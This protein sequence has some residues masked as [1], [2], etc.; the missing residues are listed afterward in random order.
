MKTE[1]DKKK[2]PETTISFYDA[3]HKGVPNNHKNGDYAF[4]QLILKNFSNLTIDHRSQISQEI[5]GIQCMAIEET[6]ELVE[7]SLAKLKTALESIPY[8]KK[9]GYIQS[10]KFSKTY[11]NEDG[12]R[13]RFLRREF[14][15]E[16]EA[17]MRLVKYCDFVLELFGEFA[18][19]RRVGLHDFSKREM[20]W[21][22]K[23]Y[24]QLLP[25]RDQTGRRIL[26]QIIDSNVLKEQLSRV[27]DWPLISTRLLA[28][29]IFLLFY[30]LLLLQI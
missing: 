7:F 5:D 9:V 8:K 1:T 30:L 20:K 27:S 26:I 2:T 18:L 10:Q 28:T 19:E 17:A 11:I 25:Y 14:F 24:V 13:L 3:M 22:L 23:G 16:R 6:P 4:N 15:D 29:V 21:M 12:F